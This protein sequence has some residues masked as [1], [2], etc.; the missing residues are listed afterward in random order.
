MAAVGVLVGFA[1]YW[2]IYFGV[3]SLQG[4]GI[5]LLDLIVPG[6]TVSHAPSAGG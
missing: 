3:S 4:P 5:G 1:G 6:R 2:L